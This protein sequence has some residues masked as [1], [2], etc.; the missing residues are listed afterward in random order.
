VL[1]LALLHAVADG[2]EGEAV[3]LAGEL[4]DAVLASPMVRLAH[5]VREGGALAIARAVQLAERVCSS[6]ETDDALFVARERAPTRAR[7]R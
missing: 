7:T 3:A 6:S 5:A 2:S 1:A 4:A